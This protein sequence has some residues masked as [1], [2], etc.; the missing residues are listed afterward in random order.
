M[1]ELTIPA[2]IV[3]IEPRDEERLLDLFCRFGNARRRAYML[4]QRGI[5]KD[6]IEKIVQEQLALNSRY[7]KDAYH[8][9]KDLPPHVRFGGL[10]LQR[11]REQGKNF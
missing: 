10:K 8:S 2:T 11:L 6:E 5:K 1:T 7:V 3:R 4:K 9:I